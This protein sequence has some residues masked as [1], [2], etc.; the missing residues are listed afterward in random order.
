MSAENNASGQLPFPCDPPNIRGYSEKPRSS[1]QKKIREELNAQLGRTHPKRTRKKNI[2]FYK[3]NLV[4]L[5]FDNW[6]LHFQVST[7][8]D[9][10]RKKYIDKYGVIEGKYLI[11]FDVESGKRVTR[12]NIS[13]LKKEIIS[14]L[15][16]AD[17]EF[18]N[19]PVWH[20]ILWEAIDVSD[21]QEAKAIEVCVRKL[22]DYVITTYGIAETILE[23]NNQQR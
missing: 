3:D 11:C 1:W 4:Q 14:A 21:I 8:G 18:K 5:Y 12:K 17:V 10:W 22:I 20:H 16:S 2:I 19:K 15:E 7:G 6:T 9:E 13:Q 23:A